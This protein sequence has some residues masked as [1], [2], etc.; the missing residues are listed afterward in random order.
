MHQI[1]VIKERL[2]FFVVDDCLQIAFKAQL[3]HH[4]LAEIQVGVYV[5]VERQLDSSLAYLGAMQRNSALCLRFQH[6]NMQLRQIQNC[7][8]TDQIVIMRNV[9]GWGHSSSVV[10]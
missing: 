10:S 1:E 2:P 4:V 5:Q 8:F 6:W 3:G 7:I 9:Y